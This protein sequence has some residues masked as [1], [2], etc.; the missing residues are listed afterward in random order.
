MAAG[1]G[2]GAQNVMLVGQ[3]AVPHADM[4]MAISVMSFSQTV[5][6][7]VFLAVTQ[8]VFQN[9]LESTLRAHAPEIDLRDVINGGVTAIRRLV[10]AEQPP[11]VLQAYNSAIMQTID[12]AVAASGLSIAGALI[13]DWLSLKKKT[14]TEKEESL[15]PTTSETPT[16]ND[17]SAKCLT[18][19]ES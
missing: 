12:I 1:V 6:S 9:S 2:L 19:G 11:S 4:A 16:A 14:E 17:A 7:S 5:S 18:L 10:T 3:V 8:A 13:M 15:S